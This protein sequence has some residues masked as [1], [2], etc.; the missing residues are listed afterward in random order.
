MGGAPCIRGLRIPVADWSAFSLAQAMRG[1]EDEPDP[2]FAASGLKAPS[3][4]RT[5]RLAVANRRVLLG[6][7]GRLAPE[8]LRR[9]HRTLFHCTGLLL[10]SR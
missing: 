6:A 1:M 7:I 10:C 4:I 5:C 8:R 2:D 3:V 9:I